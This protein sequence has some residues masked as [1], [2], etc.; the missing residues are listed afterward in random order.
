MADLISPAFS[1][2]PAC[3]GINR[4]YDYENSMID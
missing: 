1:E 2:F 3:S 4:Q